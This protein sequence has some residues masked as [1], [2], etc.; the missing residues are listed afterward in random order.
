MSH[1]V[2]QC[3][4]EKNRWLP[5]SGKMS[6]FAVECYQNATVKHPSGDK[7]ERYDANKESFNGIVLSVDPDRQV[8]RGRA[9]I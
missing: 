6:E 3:C 2:Q 7:R 8:R 1:E 4:T 9:I 5:I